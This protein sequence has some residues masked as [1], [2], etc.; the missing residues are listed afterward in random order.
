MPKETIKKAKAKKNPLLDTEVEK[1]E[2][3]T[4]TDVEETDV[5]VSKKTAGEV[6][7]TTKP[8]EP[9]VN[10]A[11]A[12]LSDIQ[13]TKKILDADTKVMFMIPLGEG[14]KKGSFHDCFINGYQYRVRKGVMT[15]VPATIA[16]LLAEHYKVTDEAGEAYRLDRNTEKADAVLE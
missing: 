10:V 2:V 4:D 7:K 14:E 9:K 8:T 15:E 1:D 16:N 12:L 13:L 11:D 3:E 5:D 6:V